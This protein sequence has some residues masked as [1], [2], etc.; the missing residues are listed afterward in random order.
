MAPQMNYA[1]AGQGNGTR[2]GNGTG[3]RPHS[4]GSTFHSKTF[5]H[6][7]R[8][9]W[10]TSMNTIT[11]TALIIA[12]VAA[13]LLSAVFGGVA[14][15][16]QMKNGGADG[17]GWM[18][19]AA[20]LAFGFGVLLFWVII[21]KD[22]LQSEWERGHNH[23]LS[24]RLPPRLYAGTNVDRIARSTARNHLPAVLGIPQPSSN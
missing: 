6:L 19:S 1:P 11:E 18:W 10:T 20:L 24:R 5:T 7:L 14:M 2:S 15:T 17:S 13:V 23:G 12:F 3:R 22:L 4:D 8:P 16:G 21:K 9:T